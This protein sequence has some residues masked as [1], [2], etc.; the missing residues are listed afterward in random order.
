MNRAWLLGATIL[1]SINGFTGALVAGAGFGASVLGAVGW[2]L[3]AGRPGSWIA[4]AIALGLPTMATRGL[5]FGAL[6]G[7][8]THGL[9]RRTSFSGPVDRKMVLGGVILAI[10]LGG[11][12][13]VYRLRKAEAFTQ[14]RVMQSDGRVTRV[15]ASGVSET[16]RPAVVLYH[17][18]SEIIATL[19]W[20]NQ[21]V[22]VA[23]EDQALILRRNAVKVDRVNLKGLDSVREV[24]G[25]TAMLRGD[26]REWL[27]M[28]VRL[29]ATGGREL[30]LIY[31]PAGMRAHQELLVRTDAGYGTVLWSSGEP[32]TRQ[33][34]ILKTEKLLRYVVRR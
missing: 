21:R 12:S 29:H 4:F 23:I 32:G 19:D 34:F 14:P 27:A 18:N 33:E 8:V 3:A 11:L 16:S 13:S 24:V 10:V 26:S 28:N 15:A 9:V 17:R 6:V 30:L 20:D 25:T 1:R 2:E 7:Y 5:L 31:D 22:G